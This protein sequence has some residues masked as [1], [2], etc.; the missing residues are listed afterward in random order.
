FIYDAAILLAFIGFMPM[1]ILNNDKLTLKQKIYVAIALLARM[2]YCILNG[3]RLEF[4]RLAYYV[5]FAV[6][7]TNS[8]IFKSTFN[9][10]SVGFVAVF[11]FVAAFGYVYTGNLS[12]H[13]TD[14]KIVSNIKS[15]EM[16]GFNGE[17]HAMVWEDF[18]KDF[19]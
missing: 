12:P 15:F 4:V 14:P 3:E 18:A 6:L 8:N 19:N 2:S 17:S 9:I 11:L 13:F 10:R 5:V 7:L 1:L 16:D